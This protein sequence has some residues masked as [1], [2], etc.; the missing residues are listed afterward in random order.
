MH[1]CIYINAHAHIYGNNILYICLGKSL[2]ELKNKHTY[3]YT[4]CLWTV[5]CFK[6]ELWCLV[7]KQMRRSYS[8]LGDIKITK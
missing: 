4:P 7:W 5:E 1:T 8:Y 3:T 2:G 6:K